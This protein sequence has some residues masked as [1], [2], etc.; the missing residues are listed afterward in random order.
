[1]FDASAGR[2]SNFESWQRFAISGTYFYQSA[3]HNCRSIQY[4]YLPPLRFDYNRRAF[5]P[6]AFAQLIHKRAFN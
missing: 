5:K 1:M 4:S 3:S 6:E 2:A